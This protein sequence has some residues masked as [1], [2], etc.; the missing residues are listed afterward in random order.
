[1]VTQT[2]AAEFRQAQAGILTLLT[3]D[4]SAFFASLDLDR[5]ERARDA[6]LEFLPLLVAQ[7]GEAGAAAA[8]DW[9]DDVRDSDRVPGRYR[10]EVAEPAPDLEV[11][12]EQTVRRAAGYFFIEGSAAL[13]LP[14]MLDPAT[15]YAL[16]PAR[17]TIIQSTERDPR[18][19]GW[20]RIARAGACDFCRMLTNRG[21]VYTSRSALFESHGHC[22]C[23]AAPA[24]TN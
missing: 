19:K 10:A 20:Q 16:E 13:A 1:M 18:A 12:T 8:A 7:Y 14:S 4:L 22:H 2:Q 3:R 9:Y 24:F 17:Q 23:V 15:K 21:A 6:L 11:R 5:P